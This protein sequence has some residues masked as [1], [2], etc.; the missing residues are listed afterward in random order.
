MIGDAP[1]RLKGEREVSEGRGLGEER[2]GGWLTE[3]R[4]QESSGAGQI[5]M[6]DGGPV[7]ERATG[8][9][10]SGRRRLAS[11]AQAWTRGERGEMGHRAAFCFEG[12]S[13]ARAKGKGKGGPAGASV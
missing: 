8:N 1:C 5:P 2:L 11:V 3:E 13:V 7:L 9:V 4:A 12:G 6:D 10:G